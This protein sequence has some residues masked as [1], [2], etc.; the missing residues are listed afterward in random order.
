MHLLWSVLISAL[1]ALPGLLL[2]LRWLG[3]CGAPVPQGTDV[4]AER[5]VLVAPRE[6]AAVF[7]TALLFRI[8]IFLAA[9]LLAGRL[10]GGGGGSSWA[11]D[12]WKK[13]DAWHYVNLAELGY[14][15]YVE[16]GQHLFVVFFPLYV[17]LVRLAA[18]VIGN[19]MAAGLLVSFL[20]FG[21]GCVYLYRLAAMAGAVSL[22]IYLLYTRVLDLLEQADAYQSG[23]ASD[24]KCIVAAFVITP[25][26]AMA[27][28]AFC[29]AIE[30]AFH[31]TRAPK[32]D[33]KG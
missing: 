27:L 28:S 7:G 11:L 14:E 22:E 21:G 5:G 3:D 6:C 31:A 33:A 8:L 26:A 9:A 25:I 29:R 10:L 4:P 12:L 17:W 16:N 23:T 13:W 1:V 15:G 30:Q 2:L 32:I 20:S 18:R 19:T 24:V